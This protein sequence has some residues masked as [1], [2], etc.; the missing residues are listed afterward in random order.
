MTHKIIQLCLSILVGIGFSVCAY[1]CWALARSNPMITIQGEFAYD[2]GYP[3]SFPYP[4]HLIERW[5]QHLQ[6]TTP[7]DPP[8]GTE[9][10]ARLIDQLWLL[11]RTSGVTT[12][13]VL[14]VLFIV[15]AIPRRQGGKRATGASASHDDE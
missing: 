4:D 5:K 1:S 12:L 6:W 13:L 9:P 8:F 3:R 7:V 10:A 14:G 11:C 15:V 2:A